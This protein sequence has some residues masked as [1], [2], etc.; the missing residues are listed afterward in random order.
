MIAAPGAQLALDVDEPA[1]E[2]GIR[3]WLTT[4]PEVE[5]MRF[6]PDPRISEMGGRS[7]PDLS[8][9]LHIWTWRSQ[10]RTDRED[11]LKRLAAL[12][13]MPFLLACEDLPS[14]LHDILCLGGL[15]PLAARHDDPHA[16]RPCTSWPAN[17]PTSRTVGA[18]DH[19]SGVGG[20]LA[21]T[22]LTGVT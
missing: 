9:A 14:R 6:A 5:T 15:G 17:S 11:E 20:G 19:R 18:I 21:A 1:S 2:E 13:L 7:H 8:Q 10:R 16:E 4:N 22:R 3:D 12:D